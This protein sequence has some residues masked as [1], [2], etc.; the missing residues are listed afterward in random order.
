MNNYLSKVE[1]DL[2]LS[3]LIDEKPLLLLKPLSNKYL[4]HEKESFQFPQI[5]IQAQ[6]YHVVNK[7]ILFF[8]YSDYSFSIP[9][10]T[11]LAVLFHFKGRA[12]IFESQLSHLEK[13][14]ALVIS[15]Y[16]FKQS[17]DSLSQEKKIQGKFYF[18][19]E[20][21]SK[22]FVPFYSRPSISLF[23]MQ[24][25]KD[26]SPDSEIIFK[27]LIQNFLNKTITLSDLHIDTEETKLYYPFVSAALYLSQKDEQISESFLGRA[28]PM[29]LLFLSDT[30]IVFASES[31]QSVMHE[32]S[33][34]FI[35]IQIPVLRLIRH[36]DCTVFVD[37][38]FF[39]SIGF[40]KKELAFCK[41]TFIQEENRRL[42]QEKLYGL[43]LNDDIS[44]N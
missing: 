33:E 30:D 43:D 2:I 8:P 20:N 6:S 44:K 42:L 19:L 10:N 11:S 12:L 7:G 27:K 3:H 9:H 4:P 35:S 14:Y 17:D 34:Y 32:K 39:D 26:F 29:E 23:S 5:T 36:I 18:G 1:R 41:I 25:W 24:L 16:I 21:E 28:H 22:L 40:G 31:I 37:H 38:I 13:G 15:A